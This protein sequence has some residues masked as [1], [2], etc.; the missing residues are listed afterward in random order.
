MWCTTCRR[1]FPVRD[2]RT[3][4]QCRAPELPLL[5]RDLGIL[6]AL[7]EH[8]FLPTSLLVRLFP[9]D[10]SRTPSAAIAKA[11]AKRDLQPSG[12]SSGTNLLRRLQLLHELGLADRL[13]QGP[14]TEYV[15]ALTRAGAKFLTDR[16][17]ELPLPPT[18]NARVGGAYVEHQIMIAHLAV[19]LA[20]VLPLAH[21]ELETFI[22]ET[23]AGGRYQ[24]AASFS[25][26]GKTITLV[27]DALAIF[28]DP[29]TRSASAFAIECDRATMHYARLADR[30]ARYASLLDAGAQ[31][32]TFGVPAFN[33]LVVAPT[34]TRAV[35]I[36]RSILDP[37]S[38]I[39]P[40][41]RGLYFIGAE[42]SFLAAP[43]NLLAA[44]WLSPATPH[45]PAAIIGSPLPLTR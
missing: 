38:P 6:R 5:D 23:K 31:E 40:R 7:A 29:R 13:W 26:R 36:A 15:Y 20:E 11:L 21:L 22:R 16:Q 41:R 24:L 43:A 3:C 9:P 42:E 28:V 17:P 37:D 27:P 44:S 32:R 33:V 2:D 8:R 12:T 45:A 39:P 30:L 25:H 34:R 19:L 10:S 14:G 35:G 18:D 1:E 4:P